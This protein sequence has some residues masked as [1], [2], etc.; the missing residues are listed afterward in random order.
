MTPYQLSI[1]R[2]LRQQGFA[3]VVFTP[4]EVGDADSSA[5]EDLM[6]ERG[7]NFLDNFSQEKS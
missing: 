6:V 1:V 2:Q 3:V 4:K 5:L 7:N